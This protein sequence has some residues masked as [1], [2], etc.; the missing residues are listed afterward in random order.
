MATISV[1]GLGS[2]LDIDG[3]ISKLVAVKQADIDSVTAQKTTV[4]AKQTELSTVKSD[5]SSLLSSVEDL[6]DS[7]YG[8]SMDLFAKKTASSSTSSVATATAS[9]TASTQSVSIAVSQ[10][11]TSTVAKSTT[12]VAS[13]IDRDTKISSINQGTIDDGTMSIY[14]NNQ[15]YSIS[16]SSSSTLGDVL[17]SINTKTGLNASVSSDGK[18]SISSA[19]SSY[20]IVLGSGTDTSDFANVL[21]LTKQDD[22]SYVSNKSIWKT[23]NSAALTGSSSGLASTI[24]AGTF[25]LG[26]TEY[27]ID[28]NTT[29]NNLIQNINKNSASGVSASWDSSNGKLVLTSTVTGATNINVEA[30]TSNFTD[31]MGLT[32]NGKLADN[33][34]TLGVNALA[35]VNGNSIT[36]TSNTLT[37]DVTGITGLSISLA[38][39]GSTTVSVTSDST[40]LES[41]ITSM[42]SNFNTVL[43]TVDTDTASDGKLYG[44]SVLTMIRNSLRTEI[45]SAYGSDSTYNTLASIGISTGSV[46]ASVDSD[47]NKLYFDKDKFE[48]AL[49]A[50]P[51]AVRKVLIGTSTSSNDGAL[52]A[53]KTTINNALDS[54]SGYFVSR[55]S[56]LDDE[57]S[58]LSDKI[59]AQTDALTS[60]KERIT[61]EFAAMDKIISSLKSS[62]SYLG[63]TSSSS[64]SSSSSSTS[65]SSS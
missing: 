57:I 61:A 13:A 52:S 9:S 4:T 20:S 1:S 46:G 35:T 17:D 11:A 30:G 45:S 14:L 22:G 31:V 5:F 51:D 18:V 37:S 33:S 24:T 16:V 36:S 19:T 40:D 7:N 26:G 28:S 25:T 12:S 43:S 32:S 63:L 59:T 47:T 56:S 62:M 44:E 15:K 42:V 41:A 48:A 6:T 50:N 65:S 10:L 39:T 23:N 54:S 55:D 27:T 53:L 38:G 34:Q 8:V 60:Y 49:A 64:S 3:W 2:N 21:G 58:T 29:M